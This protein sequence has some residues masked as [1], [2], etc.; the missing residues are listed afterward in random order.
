MAKPNKGKGLGA[1]NT[2]VTKLLMALDDNY[3]STL[4][5]NEKNAEVKSLINDQLD[6]AKG[7]SGGSIIDFTRQNI[8]AS[9]KNNNI[10]SND[11]NDILNFIKHNSGSLYQSYIERNKNRFVETKD[12]KFVSKFIPSLG[13]AVKIALTH[14]VSSDDLSGAVKRG[15]DLGKGVNDEEAALVMD[16]I[17]KFENETN[18]LLKLKNFVYYNSL[19]SG[20]HYVYAVSYKKLFEQ[21][22]RA[23]AAAKKMG[24]SKTENVP[25]LSLSSVP[26][27]ES[28]TYDKFIDTDTGALTI[29]CAL[30]SAQLDE[31]RNGISFEGAVLNGKKLSDEKNFRNGVINAIADVYICESAI[32]ENI[33]DMM[34]I[35]VE[36]A[37]HDR[38]EFGNKMR[39][40]ID[41]ASA[42]KKSSSSIADGTV[43]TSS[44]KGEKFDI[45]GTYLKFIDAKNIIKLE[46]LGEV[47][48]YL[49]VESAK[50]AKT[51][52]GV[53]FINGDLT[54]IKREETTEKIAKMLS[55]QVIKNF[56]ASY[57]KENI[58]F[59]NLIASC[60]MANGVINT[61]YK[62][63]FI[64]PEDIFE[65]PI[66]VDE[67]GN[68]VSMLRDSLFPAK[69]LCSYTMRKHLNYLNKSGDKNLTYFRGGN[70]DLNKRN[71]EQRII[72]NLQEQNITFGDMMSDQSLM[73]Q[74]FSSDNNILIPVGKSGNKL[75]EFEKLE[76]QNIDM[77]TEYEKMLENQAIIATGVPPLLIEQY[78]Q[79]DFSKAYTT[80]HIGF[81]G[82]VAGWQSDLE[83]GSSRLYK[84]IIENLDI[85]DNIKARI[86]PNIKFKLPRPKALAAINN[87]EAIGNATTVAQNYTQLKYGE[88]ADD[89]KEQ[90]TAI[91]RAIVR[92][93]TPFIDW[94]H[95]DDIAEET[96]A[97]LD[98][99][100]NKTGGD[101]DMANASQF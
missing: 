6:L 81:A 5:L 39:D 63:Q 31:I 101:A 41:K 40:K 8:V 20:N 43:D 79:A 80:A 38:G 90:I 54:N 14:I 77:S 65:F 18:L 55:A 78:N 62:I 58:Q 11:Q 9:K 3:V 45:T 56:S 71:H 15:I 94:E 35:A 24:G 76:G 17:E 25:S 86:L 19:V 98:N 16:A 10:S 87:T 32:P 83:G 73:F 84:R 96:L 51:S 4:N 85:S 67:N 50:K 30:E 22:S 88:G 59:K 68:G 57:V 60:I 42:Y 21:Y 33:M 28:V 12:L 91:Q 37:D 48:G 74:K 47:I 93:Q 44:A 46:V 69:I 23:K 92:D 29:K 72:R 95:F 53:Q 66:N 36:A 52:E 82:I 2:I 26:A 27:S 75:V 100:T 7:T 89:K 99:I 34:E 97:E 1:M 70:A 49:Y 64:P 61:E 13:Q